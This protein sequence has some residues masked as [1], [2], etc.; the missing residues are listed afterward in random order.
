VGGPEPEGGGRQGG[1]AGVEEV[2]LILT[3][4]VRISWQDAADKLATVGQWIG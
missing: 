2:L 3:G 1:G 4:Q